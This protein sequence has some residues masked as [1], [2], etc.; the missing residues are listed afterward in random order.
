[1]VFLFSVK[2]QVPSTFTQYIPVVFLIMFLDLTTTNRYKLFGFIF[3][4]LCKTIMNNQLDIPHNGFLTDR[5]KEEIM[6]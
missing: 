4:Y 5:C 6:E 1:M 3:K 2:T